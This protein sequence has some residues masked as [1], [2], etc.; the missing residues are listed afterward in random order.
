MTS[1]CALMVE[2]PPSSSHGD[3]DRGARRPHRLGRAV[4]PQSH[5]GVDLQPCSPGQVH[6]VGVDLSDVRRVDDDRVGRVR[7]RRSRSC[8]ECRSAF[9]LFGVSQLEEPPVFL[10]QVIDVGVAARADRRQRAR[11]PG[12]GDDHQQRRDECAEPRADQRPSPVSHRRCLSAAGPGRTA[13]STAPSGRCCSAF[14]FTKY[15]PDLQLEEELQLVGLDDAWCRPSCRSPLKTATLYLVMAKPPASAGAFHSAP[16]VSLP[17]S[18]PCEGLDLA[19]LGQRRS[20]I[21]AAPRHARADALTAATL[22][23]CLPGPGVL[24]RRPTVP[25]SVVDNTCPS[26]QDAVRRHGRATVVGRRR[27]RERDLRPVDGRR[28]LADDRPCGAAGR[29]PGQRAPRQVAAQPPAEV[30]VVRTV[31]KV[32]WV[33]RTTGRTMQYERRRAGAPFD[34]VGRLGHHCRVADVPDLDLARAACPSRR[35]A[36]SAA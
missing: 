27:P 36:R 25:P 1:P 10:F 19:R 7:R 6:L 33:V 21:V 28:T 32:F 24:D 12:R 22:N 5:A 29:C 30:W 15:L 2:V 13:C 14:T 35:P 34:A 23:V 3:L 8:P 11:R 4:D 26:T 20:L 17:P 9:Q 18:L 31:T 16:A